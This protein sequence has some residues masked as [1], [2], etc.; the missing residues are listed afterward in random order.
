MGKKSKKQTDVKSYKTPEQE[1]KR[2][3]V[4]ISNYGLEVFSLI[5]DLDANDSHV[6][7]TCLRLIAEKAPECSV[8]LIAE[9]AATKDQ[10]PLLAIAA[11]SVND[12]LQLKD[13]VQAVV[14]S[15]DGVKEVGTIL[16][17]DVHT[18]QLVASEPG[19]SLLKEKDKALSASF[20]WLKKNGFSAES[21]SDSG[22]EFMASFQFE[23]E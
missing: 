11:R 22:E 23:D 20:Q 7:P 6:L 1:A 12:E 2:A 14:A 5:V 21:E 3:L 18:S 8:L 4:N 16:D 15:M 9:T 10:L 17:E 19:V 13:W